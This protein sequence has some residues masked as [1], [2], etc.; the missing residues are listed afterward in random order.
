MEFVY[1]FG[2]GMPDRAPEVKSSEQLEKLG[3][4]TMYER[5]DEVYY[6]IDRNDFIKLNR[7]DHEIRQG[8]HFLL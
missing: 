1:D 2:I 6:V 4:R 3:V 7:K 5:L 8:T